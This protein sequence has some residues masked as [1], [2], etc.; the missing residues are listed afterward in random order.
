MGSAEAE[1]LTLTVPQREEWHLFGCPDPTS[2]ILEMSLQ[3]SRVWAED[4]LSRLAR[5]ISLV[6]IELKTEAEPV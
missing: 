5:N 1:I 3:F 6:I 4:N 2:E